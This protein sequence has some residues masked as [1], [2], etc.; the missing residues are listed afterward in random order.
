MGGIRLKSENI[1]TLFS[2]LS[3]L[4]QENC[5]RFRFICETAKAFVSSKIKSGSDTSDNSGRLEFAAAALAYYRYI[6]WSV[7][8]GGDVTVGEVSV[9]QSYSEKL[10]ASVKLC[11]EAFRDISDIIQNDGFV[12]ERI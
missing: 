5:I 6:L 12:F 2:R 10:N 11:E 1:L 9:K 4:D 3:G 7:T 8:D